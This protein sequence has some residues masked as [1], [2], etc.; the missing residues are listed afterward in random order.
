MADFVLAA[1]FMLGAVISILII[2]N[3]LST[4]AVFISLTENMTHEERVQ[5]AKRS[6]TYS[7]GILIF[8]SVTGLALFQVFGF[9]LG[10]FRIAG[11]ILLF[12]M[13]VQM[14]NPKPSHEE[15]ETKSRDIALIPLSIPFTSGPGT[16]TTVVVLMSEAQNIMG[17]HGVTT[18]LMSITGI[19]IGIALCI[20]ISYLMMTRS[21]FIDERLKEG[22]RRI[23]TR[24]MGLLV[25]AIAVQFIINGMLD[26]LPDFIAVAQGG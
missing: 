24:L 12:T 14:L 2:S 9:S 18:G 22:G 5:T 19:Y 23:V 25:M 15:A 20:G 6:V 26:V 10:A 4:S 3:P 16:I 8:F 11:G 13:A 17:I 1:E 21:E 7:T